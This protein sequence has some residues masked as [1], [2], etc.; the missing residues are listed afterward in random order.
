VINKTFEIFIVPAIETD[1]K[2]AKKYSK[3]LTGV[4]MY[5]KFI[6][7]TRELETLDKLLKESSC[8]ITIH[9]FGGIGKT[10]LAFKAVQNFNSGKVLT[11]P[12]AGNPTL[13]QVIQKILRFLD[14]DIETFSDPENPQ[15]EVIESLRN[16][17]SLLFFLDN[18][19]DIKQAMDAGNKEAMALMGFF[20]NLP[21]NVKILATSRIVLGWHDEKLVELEGLAPSEG[22]EVFRQWIPLRKH[23]IDD[24]IALKL[25][26]L[27]N[28]HPLSLRLLGGMFNNSHE[29][30]DQFIDN[31][32]ERLSKAT[33]NLGN[34]GNLGERHKTIN[35]CIKYSFDFMDLALQSFISFL[36]VFEIPFTAPLIMKAFCQ[37]PSSESFVRS[38]LHVL[39]QHS[40]LNKVEYREDLALGDWLPRITNQEPASTTTRFPK[41]TS[42]Q[43]W[44]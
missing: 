40:W 20:T 4:N 25:S 27:A 3:V 43:Y 9:G 14:I 1:K 32:G 22:I 37:K 15:P 8:N 21:E 2:E 42:S 18:V 13:S 7:R 28:G 24:S 39:W 5:G 6:G 19:E 33:G 10:A 16:E 30:L 12:L 23:E 17:E 29:P 38:N 26:G 36:T 34:L 44:G 41:R 31:I 11:L 35:T